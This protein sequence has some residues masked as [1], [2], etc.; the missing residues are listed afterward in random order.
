M[1]TYTL[2]TYTAVGN[3]KYNK[4]LHNATMSFTLRNLHRKYYSF[5]AW[6]FSTIIIIFFPFFLEMTLYPLLK[7]PMQ[8]Q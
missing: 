2:H 5:T 7:H 3:D 6:P 4:I 8:L 1:Q